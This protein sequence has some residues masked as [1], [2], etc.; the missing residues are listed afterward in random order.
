MTPPSECV[1]LASAGRTLI[2]RLGLCVAITSGP[3]RFIY[4][5]FDIVMKIEYWIGLADILL[6]IPDIHVG[7]L[8]TM[9]DIVLK[10]EYWIGWIIFGTLF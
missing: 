8:N 2:L 6:R 4:G 7:P 1:P 9:S 5:R 3:G 10:N